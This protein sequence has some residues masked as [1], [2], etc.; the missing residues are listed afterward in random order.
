M[1][2]PQPFRVDSR[3][4]SRPEGLGEVLLSLAN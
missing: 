3:H 2:R 4:P 1:F